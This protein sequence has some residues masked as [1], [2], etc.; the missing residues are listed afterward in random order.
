MNP[1]FDINEF[2]EYMGKPIGYLVALFGMIWILN[3]TNVISS[4]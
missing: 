1:E 2:I 3:K 4:C